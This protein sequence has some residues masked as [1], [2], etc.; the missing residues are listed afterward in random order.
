MLRRERR[1]RMFENR[2]VRKLFRPKWDE[3]VGEWRR[4]RIEERSDLYS[5]PNIIRVIKSRRIRWAW[6]V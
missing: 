1:L 3:N 4:L 6:Y 2:V 5:P